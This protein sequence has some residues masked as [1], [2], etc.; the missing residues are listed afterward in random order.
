MSHHRR[1]RPWIGIGSWNPWTLALLALL[2]CRPSSVADAE[3]KGDASWL[4]AEGSADAVSALGRLADK[5]P[6]ALD[7]L[8]KRSGFDTNAYIAAWVAAKRGQS[9]GMDMLRGGL[10][11]PNR[12]EVTASSMTRRDAL[13]ASFVSDIEAAMSRLAAGSSGASLGALLASVGPS[14]HA[15]VER[16]LKDGASRGAMCSGIAGQDASADARGVL[17]SVPLESRDHVL[18]VSAVVAMAA[19]DDPAIDWLATTAEPGLI[20]SVAKATTVPCA[21]LH[22]LWT[23]ALSHRSPQSY[24]GLTVPINL[25]IKRCADAMDGV[26]SDAIIHIPGVRATIVQAIDPYAG[27]TADLKA[28]CKLLPQIV[29]GPDAPIVR[30]RANDQLQHGCKAR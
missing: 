17:I 22:L 2:G 18:C 12:A 24:S 14:A 20:S 19:T 3:A 8:K 11:N 27:E 25:S 13:L 15:A 30:E 4:D 26:L 10:A 16:R 28:T 29:N 7:L 5:S 9:W 1:R 21:R 6:R 23:K